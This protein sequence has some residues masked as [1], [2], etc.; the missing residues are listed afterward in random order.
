MTAKKIGAIAGVAALLGIGGLLGG[1]LSRDSS[2]S[3]VNA[4]RDEPA[5]VAADHALTGFSLGDTESLVV[6]LQNTVREN[7]SDVQSLAL[8]GLAYQQRARETGDPA[9]Y[10]KSEGVLQEALALEPDDLLSTSG[11]GSLALARHDFAGALRLGEKARSLSPDTA[12]NYGVI[13][14]ALTELGRYKDAFAAFDEMVAL[15]PGI[16][17]Y[18]RVSYARELRGDPR[19]AIQAMELAVDAARGSQEPAAWAMTQLG[20]IHFS[21]GELDEAARWYERALAA[22]PGYVYAL[23]ALA[24]V[25]GA[26]GDYPAAI[27]LARKVV[28]SIP[29]PQFVTLLGDLYQVSGQEKL[30]SEQYDLMGAIHQLLQANGVRSDL[31]IAVFYADHGIKL[32]E[33]LELA[34]AGRAAR[35]S[36]T[37]DDALAWALERNGRCEEALPYSKRAL[38]LGMMDASLFFHRGMIE[39]CLG[40]RQEAERWFSRALE[41]NPG[42]SLIWTPVA[43]ALLEEGKA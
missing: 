17:S 38:R 19:G 20:K 5:A 15:K 3:P 4:G 9:Y 12:R 39:R 18:A 8:L 1:V 43:E 21:I 33:A 32:P 13:G 42:F 22:L 14:D 6:E 16:A 25:E 36:I 30:A 37:G 24:H 31:E 26:R 23:E 35:P 2:P 41:L 34:R 27:E 28:D 10:I 29:L 7:P 11:L 40:N